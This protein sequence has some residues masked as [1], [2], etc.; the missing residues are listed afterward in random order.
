M[1]Y[2]PKW[3]KTE[4]KADPFTLEALIAWLE[5]QPANATYCYT[6]TGGCLVAQFLLSLGTYTAVGVD[7]RGFYNRSPD[8][9]STYDP[10]PLP[11]FFNEVALKNPRTF[12]AA[13]DRARAAMSDR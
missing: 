7:H 1:L 12:G 11:P 8:S 2:D 13:L 6:S 5:K 10:I 9:R 3:E 4:T